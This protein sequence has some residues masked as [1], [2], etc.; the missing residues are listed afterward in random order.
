RGI[1]SVSGYAIPERSGGF[2]LDLN[3]CPFPP[4]RTVVEALYSA[5]CYAN[6]YPGRELFDR[7]RQLVADYAGVNIDNVVVF[8]GGDEGLRV[9]FDAFVGKGDSVVL[10]KPG[11]AMARVYAG[12]RD[13]KIVSVA[14][15]EDGFRWTIDFGYLLEV[16]KKARLVVIENPHNPTG[17][18]LLAPGQVRELLVE[19][20]NAMVLV[21][22]AYYEFAGVT[23]ASLVRDYPNLLVLRTLSK[24]FCLAG[25][26]V[27]YLLAAEE[28]IKHVARVLPPFTISR[29]SLA[30]AIEALKNRYYVGHVVRFVVKERERLFQ[31]I[32]R[33]DGFKAYESK[34]NF[35]LV[36]TPENIDVV[37][38]ALEQGIRIKRVGDLPGSYVRISIGLRRANELLLEVLREATAKP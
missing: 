14:L 7:L 22:E 3:E 2:L 36:R 6:R 17:S 10:T 34:T 5:G 20:E 9:V 32:N 4:P 31:E 28:T 8:G 37:E 15:R 11:F 30:A 19:A 12:I 13:A 29:P 24:A 33:I 27:G 16:A 18:L 1:A 25:L 38:L 35:L 21:D 23:V 26:R